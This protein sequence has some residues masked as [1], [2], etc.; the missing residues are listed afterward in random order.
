MALS[1][2]IAS[3]T[4]GLQEEELSVGETI[5]KRLQEASGGFKRLEEEAPRRDF[6]RPVSPVRNDGGQEGEGEGRGGGLVL[7][8]KYSTESNIHIESVRIL[9]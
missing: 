2:A 6:K 8:L 4:V 5:K 1:T 3:F 7:K 9:Y